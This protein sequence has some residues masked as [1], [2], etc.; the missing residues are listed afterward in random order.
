MRAVIFYEFLVVFNLIFGG[1][2]GFGGWR[3]NYFL[4]KSH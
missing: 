2:F 4:L 3:P 1:L